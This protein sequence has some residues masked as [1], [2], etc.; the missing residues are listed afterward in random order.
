[1][2]NKNPSSDKD[3]I[4]FFCKR[5]GVVQQAGVDTIALD[6]LLVINRHKREHY[7]LFGEQAPCFQGFTDY[8]RERRR[9]EATSGDL[10]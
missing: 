9:A 2:T 1:M 10:L 7:S 5:V 8:E 4:H 3:P 6:K